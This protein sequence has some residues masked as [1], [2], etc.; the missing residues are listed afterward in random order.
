MPALSVLSP[1]FMH[2]KALSSPN[3]VRHI[4]AEYLK[5]RRAHILPSGQGSQDGRVFS[6]CGEVLDF[7]VEGIGER[8]AVHGIAFTS[9]FPGPFRLWDEERN[10][11]GT[12]VRRFWTTALAHGSPIA[13]L[14]TL[15]FHRHDQVRIP[16]PPHVIAYPI[17]DRTMLRWKAKTG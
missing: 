8:L 2:T 7:L 17:D 3:D 16:A 10:Q 14:C 5:E 15:F 13:R 6:W 12:H 11:D 9:P 4:V 1:R